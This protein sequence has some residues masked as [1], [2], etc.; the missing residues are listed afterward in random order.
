MPASKQVIALSFSY[1]YEPGHGAA[2]EGSHDIHDG[3]FNAMLAAEK[4]LLDSGLNG[5]VLRAGYIYGGQER[6]H[7]SAGRKTSKA[8]AH[9]PMATGRR[10][11]FM[12]MIWRRPVS[13]LL[14]SGKRRHAGP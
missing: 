7:S 11:G 8:R 13:S 4:A 9:C 14:N 2:K 3:D 1:L 10:P 6:W 12:K 5:F